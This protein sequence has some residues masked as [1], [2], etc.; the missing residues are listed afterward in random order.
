M[1][2][3][4]SAITAVMV[5]WLDEAENNFLCITILKVR[6]LNRSGFDGK[7]DNQMGIQRSAQTTYGPK[8]RIRYCGEETKQNELANDFAGALQ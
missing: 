4:A 1:E 2:S 3:T 8:E 5:S 6:N 7:N